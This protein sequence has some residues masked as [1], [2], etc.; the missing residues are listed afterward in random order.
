M[1][2]ILYDLDLNHISQTE[3]L[4]HPYFNKLET[5]SF[6]ILERIQTKLTLDQNPNSYL[7]RIDPFLRVATET[8]SNMQWEVQ[9]AFWHLGPISHPKKNPIASNS[10][11]LF[12]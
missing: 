9:G 8:E 3:Q 2:V 5:V 6:G 4:H 1:L 7:K 10:F 11:R 12:R